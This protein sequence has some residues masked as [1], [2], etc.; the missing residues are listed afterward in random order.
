MDHAQAPPSTR[1]STPD[2][3]HSH[4]AC[5]SP[6][7]E[8]RYRNRFVASDGTQNLSMEPPRLGPL[9]HRWRALDAAWDRPF[10][11]ARAAPIPCSR[12]TATA[13]AA[14]SAF[15][16]TGDFRNDSVF[17]AARRTRVGDAP[18][19]ATAAAT[20]WAGRET[21]RETEQQRI[22]EWAAEAG[23]TRRVRTAGTRCFAHNCYWGSG[24]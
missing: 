14:R 12:A 11:T 1:G 18:P 21:A 5:T 22:G 4:L 16:R 23:A 24:P 6:R 9:S 7:I 10:R 20:P 19:A 3:Q 15:P 13:A 2:R 17:S 8:H